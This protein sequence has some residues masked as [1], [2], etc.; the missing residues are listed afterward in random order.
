MQIL[1]VE[2]NEGDI[3]LITE[4]LEEARI[5]NR[6]ETVNDGQK[7]IEYLKKEG[8]YKQA[9]IPDLILLDINL[10][11]KNGLEVLAFVKSTESLKQ[12]PVVMLTT[13]SSPND[14]EEANKNYADS[15]MTKPIDPEN[16]MKTIYKIENFW[17][18]IVQ[19]PPRNLQH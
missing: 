6:V 16:F 9:F 4:V 12:I 17:L 14:M 5:I 7:A 13:S 2:D 11:R 18:S 10:P 1:L 8:I 3:V 19:L 15:Y